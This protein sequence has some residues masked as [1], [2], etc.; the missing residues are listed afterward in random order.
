MCMYVC[1]HVY[2]C[3]VEPTTFW[4]DCVRVC[5]SVCICVHMCACMCVCM[6]VRVELELTAFQEDYMHVRVKVRV[7]V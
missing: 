3:I 6:Y 1:V 5:I 7:Y 2:V 4:K